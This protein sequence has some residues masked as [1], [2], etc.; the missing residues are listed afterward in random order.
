MIFINKHFILGALLGILCLGSYGQEEGSVTPLLPDVIPPSPTA[1]SI[2]RYG[3]LPVNYYTGGLSLSLPLHTAQGK[4]LAV[5]ISL[6]YASSGCKVDAFASWVGDGWSA[7]AGGVISRTMRGK[8]DERPGVGYWAMDDSIP[9]AFPDLNPFLQWNPSDAR[10]RDLAEAAFDAQPD[11][12]S[13]NFLNFSG[14]F[15]IAPDGSVHGMPA[16]RLKIEFDP[17][18]SP[19]LAWFKVTTPD[20]NVFFFEDAESTQAESV[21]GGNSSF[22]IYNSSWYLSRIVSADR[23]DTV[24]FDY[25]TAQITHP[26]SRSETDYQ[27]AT[28][29]SGAGNCAVKSPVICHSIVNTE[30]RYL[31]DIH[32]LREHISFFSNG[33]RLDIANARILDSIVVERNGQKLKSFHFS[34]DYFQSHSGLSTFLW[35]NGVMPNPHKRLR[36]DSFYEASASGEGMPSFEFRYNSQP[37]PPY[38]SFAM[39]HWGYYNGVNNTTLLPTQTLN[40]STWAGANREPNPQYAVAGMLEEITYPTGGFV[41]F[42]YEGHDYGSPGIYPL[43]GMRLKKQIAGDGLNAANDMVK[44]YVYTDPANPQNSSGKI[45][46]LPHYMHQVWELEVENFQSQSGLSMPY[47]ARE[48]LHW[49]RSSSTQ[50]NLNYTKGSPVGYAYVTEILGNNGEGGKTVMHFRTGSDPAVMIPPFTPSGSNDHKR[51][52]LLSKAIYDADGNLVQKEENSFGESLAYKIG[53]AVCTYRKKHIIL[54][55]GYQEFFFEKFYMN[56]EW[57]FPT[58]TQVTQY[59]PISGAAFA[60]TTSF[61]YDNPSHFL[62]TRI[63]KEKSTGRLSVLK[64]KYVADYEPFV[65]V[66]S[67]SSL[68]IADMLAKNMVETVMEEQ[69]WEGPNVNSLS[70]IAGRVTVFANWSASPDPDKSI[71]KP[72]A[73]WMLETDAPIAESSFVP[74]EHYNNTAETYWQLIP[75]YTQ[76]G[77]VN[78]YVE[79]ARFRFGEQGNLLE[80]QL[81]GG[82]PTAYIWNK[83]GYLPLAKVG[84]AQADEIAFSSFEEEGEDEEGGFRIVHTNGSS[85]GWMNTPFTGENSFNLSGKKLTWTAPAGVSGDF[86]LSFWGKNGTFTISQTAS[87]VSPQNGPNGWQYREFRFSLQAN[88]SLEI[89][90]TGLIDEVRLMPA[91]ALFESTYSFDTKERVTHIGSPEGQAQ[92]FDYD[93]FNRLKYIIDVEGNFRQGLYYNYKK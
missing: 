19:S 25:G 22:S 62:P 38:G 33:N 2:A 13:Y 73:V 68:T 56:S 65:V 45:L 89:Y 4:S 26:I 7:N 74:R 91:D 29:T 67:G 81:V 80:Q 27:L 84:N 70:L 92:R 5:P 11:I 1:A 48:C 69:S 61:S 28:Q 86:V 82:N 42:E 15:F 37:I 87:S 8:E 10:K 60:Q 23:Q 51:G 3:E 52:Q 59:D 49:A 64:K 54:D 36:L 76:D 75:D 78:D 44:N 41:A 53:G 83:G 14:K 90:G 85:N 88:Q 24:T 71:I 63:V 58:S 31:T 46:A 34:H 79:R 66:E 72:Y 32:T 35:A 93:S 21:C 55:P 12:F 43:G 30:I 57:V 50:T 39:D 77:L 16:H 20:G 40:G 17:L 9:D 6:S 47:V 18:P